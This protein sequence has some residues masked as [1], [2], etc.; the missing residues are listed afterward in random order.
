MPRN[1]LDVMLIR[2]ADLD[3][4][5]KLPGVSSRLTGV[6]SPIGG[7]FGMVRS[8]GHQHHAG[9]DLYA[10]EGSSCYAV[11]GGEW[12]GEVPGYGMTLGV[13]LLDAEAQTVARSL[14]K[15]QL[16]AL[17]SHLSQ[18]VLIKSSFQPGALL[19]RTGKSGTAS[20]T[21]PHLH[22]ELRTAGVPKKGDGAA[23]DPAKL[24]G[25]ALLACRNDDHDRLNRIYGL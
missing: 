7:T 23:V 13:K 18:V 4:L 14:A 5:V 16:F 17:Y 12:H 8:S 19:A 22:F 9:W 15:P 24:F 6:A 11:C 2:T 1:P 10:R 21:P 3:K 20:S 25:T